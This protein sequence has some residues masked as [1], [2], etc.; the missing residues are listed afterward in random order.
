M[1]SFL[2]EYNFGKYCPIIIILSLLQTEINYDNVYH[3][4][5]HHT[6]NLLVYLPCKMNKMYWPSLLACFHN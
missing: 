4:I 2:F 3:K 5:Y 6:S 1:D